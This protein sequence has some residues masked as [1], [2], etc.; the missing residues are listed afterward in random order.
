M[1]NSNDLSRQSLQSVQRAF[2]SFERLGFDRKGQ[3]TEPGKQKYFWV[4]EPHFTN[5]GSTPAIDVISHFDLAELPTGPPT[6]QQFIGN[7]QVFGSGI[8]M[9]KGEGTIGYK[10]VD[11][12]FIL[13]DWETA[14]TSPIITKKIIRRRF[15]WGWVFYRDVFP[16][17]QPHL[18]EFCQELVGIQ[19]IQPQTTKVGNKPRFSLVFNSCPKHNCVDEYCEDYQNVLKAL[20][21]LRK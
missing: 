20:S 7:D 16:K 12:S 9:Q 18:T 14:P 6:E 1:R 2:A 4:F 8:M 13:N 3:F 10:I 15:F 21:T 5:T 19:L 17:T 11:D